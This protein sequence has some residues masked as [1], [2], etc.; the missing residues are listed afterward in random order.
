MTMTDD[1]MALLELIE[2]GADADLVREMLSFAAGR[3]MDAEVQARTG[4]AHGARDPERLVQRNGYRERAWDTRVGQIDLEIPRLRRGSYFPSFLEPRRTAEKALTAVIQEAY[5][6]GVSTRAVDDLVKAMGASGVSKSQVSRLVAEID[7]QVDAFLARP[8]EGEW[9]YL[10]IDATY[11][12]A[13]EAGRIVSTATIIAVGVNTDG[14]RDV[15]GVA[16]GPSEAELFWKGFLRSLADRGLRGVKLVIAD[17]HKGLRAAASKIFHA[18]LQR[19]RVHWM[20]NLLT[21]APTK[22]RPAVIAMVKT[23]FAQETAA[24]ARSQWKTVADALRERAPKLA[25]LMDGS[26]DDVLA[27]TAFPKEHWPQIA[28][29]NPL[30]RLNGEIKRRSN[31]VGIFPNDR[32]VIRLVGAL[33]LEQNDEWAVGRRYMSLESLAPVSDDP[34]VKLPGVAA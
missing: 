7:E 24:E 13:R 10:W 12:K 33:M 29:T 18:T 3:L 32:A 31:V 20:R 4:A 16:T 23:I 1:R 34:L 9:P 6:H 22:Q 27:Y 11:V 21:H 14:R 8:I 28:S 30:E 2:K 17:D 15:L 5:V 25:A 26:L 19:C